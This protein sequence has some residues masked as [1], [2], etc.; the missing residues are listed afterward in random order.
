MKKLR[1]IPPTRCIR[2]ATTKAR[3]KSGGGLL[4]NVPRD[5]FATLRSELRRDDALA[6]HALD[7]ARRTIVADPK[8]ALQPRDRRLAVLR[9][10]PH[11]HVVHLVAEILFVASLAVFAVGALEQLHLVAWRLLLLDEV[12]DPVDLGVGDEEIGRAYV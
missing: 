1:L 9:H 5:D 8:A 11:G 12:D 3:V 6:L 7:H 4:F 2:Q 10:E